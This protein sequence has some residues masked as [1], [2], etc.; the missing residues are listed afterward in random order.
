MSSALAVRLRERDGLREFS[1]LFRRGGFSSG[2]GD[3]SLF[4][5]RRAGVCRP[6]SYGGRGSDAEAIF[7]KRFEALSKEIPGGPSWEKTAIV[8]R[9]DLGVRALEGLKSEFSP[10]ERVVRTVKGLDLSKALIEIRPA[11][12]TGANLKFR[13]DL[14]QGQKTG[15]F[16]DQAY[17]ISVAAQKFRSLRPEK[18]PL[19]ILDLC[20]YVGQWSAQLARVFRDQ[21][22]PVEITAVDASQSA[23]D[24]ARENIEREGA[25]VTTLKADVLKDLGQ[26]RGAF[27]RSRRFAIRRRSS[28]AAKTFP[29]GKHAYLQLNTQAFRL[30]KE[31]EP[32]FLAPARAF[33]KKKSFSPHSARPL[34]AIARAF[35]G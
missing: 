7:R 10:E 4:D 17:N 20:C 27:L 32:S 12:G 26:S 18:G 24:F 25:K 29:T 30:V 15:F 14:V 16:L 6:G 35:A 2:L 21:K 22:V 28:R 1:A 31:P 9:N 11:S 8:Y 33:S 5:G 19:K 23:L 34:T 3:R 13:A